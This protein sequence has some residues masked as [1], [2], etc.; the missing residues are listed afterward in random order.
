MN[1]DEI[2]ELIALLND[3]GL[4][5]LEVSENGKTIR[6]EKA[7][8]P[9]AVSAP[10][11]IEIPRGQSASGSRAEPIDYN[12]AITSPMVGV[13][14]AS[15]S[16]EGKPFVSVGSEVKNGDVLCVIEAMKLMNE[17]L[18]DRDGTVTEICA[19]NEQIVEFGQ[20]LFRFK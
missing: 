16:P 6:L 13:Y 20:P 19:R 11:A 12:N 2:K 10:A 9:V 15:S 14:Y 3:N 5:A 8:A 1:L 17:I 7:C 18:S 4:S